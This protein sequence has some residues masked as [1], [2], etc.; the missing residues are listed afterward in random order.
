VKFWLN[1][2]GI[3]E[4]SI[5]WNID[6]ITNIITHKFKENMWCDKELMDKRKL[7]Y[8]KE[9]V[10]LNL[11][12]QKYLS[13]LRSS[14][15]KINIA[16]IRTNS[17]ELHSKTGRW[18][19]HKTPWDEINCHLCDT[20]RVE[21]E[22]HFLLYFPSYSQTISQFKNICHNT[23]LPSLLSHQNYGSWNTSL[24]AVLAQK[25]N[26]KETKVISYLLKVR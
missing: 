9:V 14:K 1:H 23:D 7:R 18:T 3:Q 21:D 11:E 4:E 22:K 24:N 5:M 6:N 16:K 12:D 25:Y 20:K 17:H 10:N 2:W 8:Y 15:K 19:I 26:F 13:V